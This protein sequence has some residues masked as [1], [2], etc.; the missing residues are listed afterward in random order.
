MATDLFAFRI[1]YHIG[2]RKIPTPHDL[3]VWY[4][5]SVEMAFDFLSQ[6]FYGS[7]QVCEQRNS[8]LS[9][10]RIVAGGGNPSIPV[11]YHHALL[12]SVVSACR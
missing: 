11:P 6:R 4:S 12:A 8:L 1:F 3:P 5:T 7:C 2:G 9:N 10:I